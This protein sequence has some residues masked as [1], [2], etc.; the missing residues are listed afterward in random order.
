MRPMPS[1]QMQARRCAPT[2]WIWIQAAAASEVAASAGA[3]PARPM[4]QRRANLRSRLLRRPRRSPPPVAPG[5]S[6]AGRASPKPP[7][8]ASRWKPAASRP[9]AATPAAARRK[10]M[11]DAAG[12]FLG[13]RQRRA[14]GGDLRGKGYSIR[15]SRDQDEARTC[16]AFSP[17]RRQPRRCR[18]AA[19]APCSGSQRYTG[20]A[21]AVAKCGTA[22]CRS[23]QGL[24]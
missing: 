6:I 2:P 22:V 19:G 16:I 9:E 14:P 21:V 5:T 10:G 15:V 17:A 7:T 24:S 4:R 11:V 3:E 12:K 18:G 1:L 13:A 8:T 20:G 23:C